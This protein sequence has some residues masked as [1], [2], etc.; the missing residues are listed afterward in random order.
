MSLGLN[1]LT[2]W[3][4]RYH[5][6]LWNLMVEASCVMPP[7]YHL[8]NIDF[9]LINRDLR[10]T[11]Q[12]SGEKLLFNHEC[13]WKLYLNKQKNSQ[14]KR[15][16]CWGILLW[17]HE[18]SSHK[19]TK[20]NDVQET[21]VWQKL[22]KATSTLKWLGHFV[23]KCDFIFWCCSPYMQYFYMKLVQYNEC[24]VSIV[25]TDGLVL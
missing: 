16:K 13:S 17:R 9:I 10:S 15:N 14:R 19:H 20:W 21:H 5:M 23:S 2:H 8:N 1:E 6:A 3:G 11:L 12:F 4:Q 7:S 24:L 25:D 22:I 18:S